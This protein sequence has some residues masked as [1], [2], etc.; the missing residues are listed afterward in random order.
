MSN[1][2]DRLYELLPAVYRIRDA[3]LG[4]PLRDLL[5]VIAEQ[6]DIVETDITQLYDNWFIETCQDWVVPYIGDLIGYQSVR[7]S[8]TKQQDNKILNP[9]R[10][11]ANTIRYQR[12]KGTLA[13]LQ[14]LADKVAGW[15]IR[16]VEFDRLVSKTQ[17]INHLRSSISTTVNLRQVDGIT[18]LNSPFDELAHTVDIHHISSQEQPGKYNT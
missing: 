18:K 11:V 8:G 12:R 5:R 2:P 3:E 14:L 10:E 13:L 6:V 16:V 1:S 9:R 7:G 15:P 17:H 4:Y